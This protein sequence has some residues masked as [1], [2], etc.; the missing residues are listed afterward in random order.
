MKFLPLKMMQQFPMVLPTLVFP[1]K[2]TDLAVSV[3]PA[4]VRPVVV[5]GRVVVVVKDWMA[6]AARPMV[7]S[8]VCAKVPATPANANLKWSGGWIP[9][10][11]I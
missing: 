11:M 1:R 8:L 9:A 2:E 7:R 6:F 4:R 5:A 10:R 3:V